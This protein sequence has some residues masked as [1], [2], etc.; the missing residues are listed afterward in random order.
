M[1]RSFPKAVVLPVLASV[2]LIVAATVAAAGASGQRNASLQQRLDSLVAA[3]PP[4]AVLLI[5]NGA[6]TQRL[7]SGVGEVANKTPMRADDLFRIASLNKSYTAAVVLQLVGEGKLR[8]DDNVEHWLPGLVPNGRNI[9][10]RELL[11]HTS[12]LF[13]HEKDQRILAPYLKGDFGHYWA[14]IQLVRM[15]VSHTPNF[16]PGKGEEYSSTNY[17]LAGLIVE[18]VTGHSIGAEL[19]N[20]IFRPLHLSDT[21]YPTTPAIP[22]PH[23]HGYFVREHPPAIDVTGISPSISPSAGAIFASADDVADFYR[24]L[25]SGHVLKPE[26]LEAMETTHAQKKYN[27]PGQ[28]PGRGPDRLHDRRQ[29]RRRCGPLDRRDRPGEGRHQRPVPQLRLDR[30]TPVLLV[31]PPPG[32]PG[33]DRSPGRGVRGRHGVA[34]VL[35]QAVP[36]V[37]QVP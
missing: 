5:R 4:G 7:V 28:R 27:V 3:G 26:L 31:A 23:A 24:A 20:R 25:L 18:K 6:D 10:I 33:D 35:G 32:F 37:A 2:A 21:S 12:G 15:A 22:G 11:N 17:I 36:L 14:P 19:R 16:A 8:L 1:T 30:A 34:R 13:D 29:P 9:T